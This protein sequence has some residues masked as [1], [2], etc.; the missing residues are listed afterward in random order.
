MTDRINAFIVV[1]EDDMR[2]DEIAPT[3]NAMKQIRGVLD[4]QPHETSVDSLIA[5]VRTR[6]ALIIRLMNVLEEALNER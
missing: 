3:L 4:V 5:H 6:S 1:L 2:E